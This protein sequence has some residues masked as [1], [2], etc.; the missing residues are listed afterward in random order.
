M[1]HFLPDLLLAM[2]E[3]QHFYGEALQIIGYGI[4]FVLRRFHGSF[5]Q[6]TKC[7]VDTR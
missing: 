7:K 1:I 2:T 5:L 4:Q 6:V 3:V